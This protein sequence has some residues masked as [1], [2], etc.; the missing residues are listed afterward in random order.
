MIEL[1]GHDHFASLRAHES[2]SGGFFHNIAITA[3]ISPRYSNNPGVTSFEI[4]DDL[5]P[6]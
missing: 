1:G 5:V 3:G 4:T 2:E 6:N